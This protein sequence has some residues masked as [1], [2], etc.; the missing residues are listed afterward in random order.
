[1]LLLFGYIK[2]RVWNKL[3]I[4]KNNLF[5][6]AGKKVLIKADIQALPA[7]CMKL[8][9]LLSSLVGDLHKLTTQFWWGRSDM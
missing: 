2:E 5:F 1:M 4:W 8:L 9:K 3:K 6:A 7:Y